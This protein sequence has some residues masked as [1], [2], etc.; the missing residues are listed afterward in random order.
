MAGQIGKDI[1]LGRLNIFGH[2][3]SFCKRS[4]RVN[5]CPP[6]LFQFSSMRNFP[7]FEYVKSDDIYLGISLLVLFVL[8]IL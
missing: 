4:E 5:V 3:A 6:Y 7:G 8:L 1:S 2:I